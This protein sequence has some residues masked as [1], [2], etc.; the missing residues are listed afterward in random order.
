MSEK[1]QQFG[2]G[3]CSRM[4]DFSFFSFNSFEDFLEGEILVLIGSRRHS[5]KRVAGNR[6]FHFGRLPVNNLGKLRSQL[7]E[8]CSSDSR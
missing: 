4:F 2:G 8:I 5:V 6:D 3:E 1:L 7:L